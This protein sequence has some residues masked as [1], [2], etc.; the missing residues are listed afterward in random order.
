MCPSNTDKR[1]IYLKYMEGFD[2]V[3]NG[4]RTHTHTHKP[5][6]NTISLPSGGGAGGAQRPPGCYRLNLLFTLQ[7]SARHLSSRTC[8]EEEKFS[9]FW[10]QTTS[11]GLTLLFFSL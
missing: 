2:L 5:H 4:W 7:A 10:N 11:L 8:S 3:G 1:R 6:S 9:T